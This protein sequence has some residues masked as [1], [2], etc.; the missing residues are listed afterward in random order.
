[1]SLRHA[2]TAVLLVLA[3]GGC[4]G[5]G[6]GTSTLPNSSTASPLAAT[7]AAPASSAGLV[8]IETDF[9]PACGLVTPGELTSI[10]GNA[11]SDGSGFTSL[12]CDWGS[13]AGE[14]SVSLLLQP[15][16]AE[17]CPGGL[18]EGEATGQ[19]GGA[20]TIHYDDL[21]GIPGAQVGVCVDGGLVLVTVTGGFGAA[22]DQA[23]YTREAVDVMEL[24]LERL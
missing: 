22:S 5:P 19:F 20:G 17:F 9:P 4:A 12:I 2:P 13:D 6:A 7:S 18:P 24:I 14:T 8:D 1:M 10:V 21:G 15:L 23:R 16:P 3:V 11:L